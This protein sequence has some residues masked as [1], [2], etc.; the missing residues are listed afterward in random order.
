M[1]F[2]LLDENNINAQVNQSVVQ[3]KKFWAD[4]IGILLHDCKFILYLAGS[5][6]D[7][8]MF[9]ETGSWVM[10]SELDCCRFFAHLLQFQLMSLNEVLGAV[11]H[12]WWDPLLQQL[13]LTGTVFDRKVA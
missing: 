4:S 11:L 2:R 9:V 8:M 6:W 1:E 7:G 12:F 3:L 5:F 10:L 13:H